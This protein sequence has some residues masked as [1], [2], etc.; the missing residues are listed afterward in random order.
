[1]RDCEVAQIP[2]N[3]TQRHRRIRAEPGELQDVAIFDLALE[4][5]LN[6][7]GVYKL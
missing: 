7:R 1:M 2:R 4:L 5:T 3:H 6:N